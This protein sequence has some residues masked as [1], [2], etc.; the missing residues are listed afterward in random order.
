MG[1]EFDARVRDVL[2]QLSLQRNNAGPALV[3]TPSHEM[4]LGTALKGGRYGRSHAVD[5]HHTKQQE[6]HSPSS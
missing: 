3:L 4:H 5:L 1:A 2:N 6:S